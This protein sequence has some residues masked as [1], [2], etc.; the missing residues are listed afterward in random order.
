MTIPMGRFGILLLGLTLIVACTNSSRRSQ[1][2]DTDRDKPSPPISS[3][4]PITFRSR[5]TIVGFET[6]YSSSDGV[7]LRYACFDYGTLSLLE[8]GLRQEINGRNVLERS[9]DFD[10]SG[11]ATGTRIVLADSRGPEPET[12]IAWTSGA[13]LF[14]LRAPTLRYALLFE[15][16]KPWTSDALCMPVPRVNARVN[17]K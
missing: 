7:A 2:T 11:K 12:T 3:G 9:T 16:S 14:L 13:R 15:E 8:G 17:L 5:G 4:E 1:T 6:N 10:E